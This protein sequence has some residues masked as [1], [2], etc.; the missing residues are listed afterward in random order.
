MPSFKGDSGNAPMLCFKCNARRHKKERRGPK[1]ATLDGFAHVPPQNETA[2]AQAVS[3]HP[4]AVAVCCGDYIDN[5]H[6][7]TGGIFEIPGAGAHHPDITGIM[8]D[9]PDTTMCVL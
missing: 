1:A 2:I 8:P 7:Y 6:T 3:Q 5:W 9:V 4:I